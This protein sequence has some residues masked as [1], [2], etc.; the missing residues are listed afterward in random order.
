MTSITPAIKYLKLR[1]TRDHI[2]PR[3]LLEVLILRVEHHLLHQLP[4]PRTRPIRR[5]H[6]RRGSEERRGR[7]RRWPCRGVGDWG[8]RVLP[9][10]GLVLVLLVAG[11][12]REEEG[13][14]AP[15]AAA[16]M[17]AGRLFGYRMVGVV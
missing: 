4:R 17:G 13:A 12:C 1:T 15:A 7:Q 6:R 9:P 3:T 8:G 5:R 16:A 14:A 2:T 11:G 10:R